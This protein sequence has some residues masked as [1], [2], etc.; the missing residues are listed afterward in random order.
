MSE[1]SRRIRIDRKDAQAAAEA[2]KRIAATEAA[3]A[4]AEKSAQAAVDN[5]TPTRIRISRP[6]A[7]AAAKAAENGR[8]GRNGNRVRGW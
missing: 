6:D 5:N 7:Q 1:A 4:A 2:A 8:S 3:L